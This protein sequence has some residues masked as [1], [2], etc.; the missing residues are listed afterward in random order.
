MSG[1]HSYSSPFSVGHRALENMW[2]GVVYVQEKIDG[3][4]FSF[5][6]KDGE[7]SFRS[8]GR[9]IDKSA[10]DMFREGVEAITA[11]HESVG[12]RDG[13][14]YRGEYLQE[15]KHNTLAYK[16]IPKHHVILF[17][18]DE[19]D[20]HYLTMSELA[21]EAARIGLEC[22]PFLATLVG[23]P[24]IETL[25]AMLQGESILGGAIEGVVLKNYAEY[26]PDKK[27][28]MAKYVSQSFNEMHNKD[29]KARHPG[30]NMFLDNLVAEYATEARWQKAV[31]HLR[32]SGEI[33]GSPKDIGL[34]LREVSKDV[35]KDAEAEI[36]EALF[37]HFWKQIA[38]GITVGLPEWYKAQLAQEQLAGSEIVD[39]YKD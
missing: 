21:D 37:Q 18:I 38:K 23:K 6:F 5:C 39:P 15:P 14:T 27:V 3:S 25:D 12:L 20:Q 22:V 32:E 35:L 28:L 33:E 31:Q 29:W 11:I 2:G 30:Q 36:K 9:Q 24:D 13:W 26:A 16:R 7:L 4:Q 8:R 19:G 34:L 10:P 17:D 1:I